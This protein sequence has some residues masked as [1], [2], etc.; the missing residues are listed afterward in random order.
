MTAGVCK[1]Q[2]LRAAGVARKY[3]ESP[4]VLHAIEA[5]HGDVEPHTVIACLVPV[6]YTH[7]PCR[8]GV[9]SPP[10]VG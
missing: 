7:L 10:G 1:S 6:S 5:H 4:E 8:G 9:P 3:K 2:G